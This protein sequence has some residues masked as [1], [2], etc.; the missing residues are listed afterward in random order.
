LTLAGTGPHGQFLRHWIESWPG[1]MPRRQPAIVADLVR[2]DAARLGGRRPAW[3][4]N[5]GALAA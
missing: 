1:K 2:L 5:Q 4:D 3:A